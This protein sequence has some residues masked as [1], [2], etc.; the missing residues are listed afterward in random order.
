MKRD[1]IQRSAALDAGDDLQK[2]G[3]HPHYRQKWPQLDQLAERSRFF[4]T[5]RTEMRLVASPTP[6]GVSC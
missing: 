6:V 3:S 5:A 2:S 1:L 4:L